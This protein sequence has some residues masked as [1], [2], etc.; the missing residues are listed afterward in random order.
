[1][2]DG[3]MPNEAVRDVYE[4][5]DNLINRE[6]HQPE[7]VWVGRWNDL[8]KNLDGV[9]N[10]GRK[11]SLWPMGF[12]LACCAIEM[13]CTGFA[14]FDIARFGAE[15][16]RPSPRQADIMIVSGTVTKKMLPAIVRLYNQMP[17]PKYVISMGACATG[18]GPFKEGYNV[19]SGIDKFLP[20]DVYIPGCPPTPSAL[21]QGLMTLQAKI[22]GQKLSDAP[23]YQPGVTEAFPVPILGPDL[24]DPRQIP[25][26]DARLGEQEEPPT[27]A[28]KPPKAKPADVPP[29]E[30]EQTA[31]VAGRLRDLVGADAFKA[32][33]NV[34]TVEPDR[35]V[36]LCFALR[37]TL[38]F[39]LLSNLTSVD[40]PDRFE[41]VYHLYNTAEGGAHVFLKVL[42]DKEDPV[43]PSLISV[44]RSADFQEREVYDMMG[45]RFA[46]HP[47]LKRILLWEGFEGFPLRKDWKEAYY[48]QEQ[49]PFE[50][51]WPEGHHVAAED[52]NIWANN[53]RYPQ[54]FD[55]KSWKPANE[56][57]MILQ[58]GDVDQLNVLNADQII[59]NLGPQHPST[60]GVFQMRV[61]LDG[62]TITDLE[63]VMGYLHR[64][65]EKIGER[66][67]WLMNMP[68]TDRLDYITGMCNNFGYAIAVEKLQG[69][70][71]PERAEYIRVI[72]AELTRIA[73]HMWAAGFLISD[74]GAFFTPATFIG[75]ERELIL[76]LFEMAAGSRMM[77]NYF[78]F[79]GV[80]Y[81]VSDE[82]LKTAHYL[83]H[84]RLPRAFEELDNYLTTN[85]IITSRTKGVGVM[86]RDLAINYG[87]TGP[88]A[89]ASG[90]NYDVRK[91]EP[92][93]IYDRFDFEVPVEYGGDVFDRYWVRMREAEQSRRILI[94]ALKDIPAGP[95]LEGTPRWSTRVPAGETY[96]RVENPK[97]ELG[98]Y[99]VSDGGSNPYRYHVRSPS[100]VN[101]TAL[102]EMCKGHKVADSIAILGSLDIVLGEVDR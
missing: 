32:E 16:F 92:Y 39:D 7:N 15:L 59:L 76:D 75:E 46:G 33:G 21:L 67:A 9:Y 84:E 80:A 50:S 82:F 101:L 78:R 64:N 23:W 77:V 22:E 95:I 85:E 27:K 79:G 86:P 72:M 96:G 47:N 71:V 44:Y 57:V 61:L 97:G 58:P 36:E 4:R 17:E 45:I 93:S 3:F 29:A 13:I 88:L 41:V 25:V 89:R 19:V 69:V 73:S 28:G 8:I 60:H 66:N 62:E 34:I 48:E 43:V 31:K 87:L 102:A 54:G 63:P 5:Y 37:D 1:M 14:R 55:A 24:V 2:K 40:Y 10:W 100:F 38:G 90:V 51:R 83:V 91:A 12:G 18:G 65:H 11:G 42:A 49:K 98:F 52:K 74:L 99:L 53:A 70:K 56:R 20:V 94:Q 68:F 26:I 35:L 30:V 6:E 81:D